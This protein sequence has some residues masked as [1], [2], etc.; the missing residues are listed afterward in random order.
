MQEEFLG[1]V[2]IFRDITH[3]VEVDRLKSEFVATVSHELRTPMTSIKGYVEVLLMGAAGELNEQQ[4][5]FL[6]V[7]QTNTER[8]NILVN[9]LLDVSR[10]DAGKYELAMQP[11]RLQDL[12]EAVVTDQLD[13][14]ETAQKPIRI[15]YDIPADLPRVRGDRDRVRQILSNL[16]SNAYHYTPANGKVIIEATLLDEEI[17]VDVTDDGIGIT[18]EEQERVFERFYRGEDPLVLATAGTGL[19]LAIVQQLIE[20]HGGHIWVKSDGIPGKGSIFSFTL[21]IFKDE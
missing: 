9:D 6:D 18:S 8:L 3:Q 2:T 19:G 20:L 21:P 7:V 5:R 11:L 14:A 10:I 16:V 12:T 17:Q 4:A 1:T 15:E 13:Q